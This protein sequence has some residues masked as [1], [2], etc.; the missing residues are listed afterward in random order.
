MNQ[1]LKKLCQAK[2]N[3]FKNYS[4]KSAILNKINLKITKQFHKILKTDH[5]IISYQDFYT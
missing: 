3:T 4:V 1:K 5:K 2:P